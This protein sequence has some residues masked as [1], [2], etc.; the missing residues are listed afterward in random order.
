MRD[1]PTLKA[2]IGWIAIG[3]S[4]GCAAQATGAAAEEATATDAAAPMLDAAP[5][6]ATS[7]E[8][9]SDE[10]LQATT[11]VDAG[12]EPPALEPCVA[13]PGVDNAPQSVLEAVALVNALPRPVTVACFLE[14]LARPLSLHA[15]QSVFSAQ[16]A[17]GARSPRLFLFYDPLIMSVVPDGAGSHLV[18]FGEQKEGQ[19]SLKAEIAF[20]VLEALP[21]AAAFERL[22]FSEALTNCAFCHASEQPS[23]EVTF[24]PAFVSEALKPLQSE[25]VSLDA[26]RFE[27][28]NCDAK[29]EPNR[30][31]ILAGIFEHGEVVDREFPKEMATFF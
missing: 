17:V 26:L 12:A 16:P 7:A 30:C 6:Q 25:R 2:A 15:S 14:A 22:M 4:T 1:A 20:P 29:A 31:A 27:Q 24:T 21:E 13:P 23:T 10:S 9:S 5:I 19:R 3:L 28:Q 18:E 8:G 11:S